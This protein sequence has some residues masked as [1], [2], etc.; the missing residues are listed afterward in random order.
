[1]GL[2]L[3]PDTSEIRLRF[4]RIK[5]GGLL[6][7]NDFMTP[8]KYVVVAEEDVEGSADFDGI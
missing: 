3:R 4:R 6:V 2:H 1:M 5:Y 7:V 8:I